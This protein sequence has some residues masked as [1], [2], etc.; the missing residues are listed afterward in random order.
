MCLLRG[1]AMFVQ[2][3]TLIITLNRRRLNGCKL[4]FLFFVSLLPFSTVRGYRLRWSPAAREIYLYDFFL[5]FFL[6]ILLLRGRRN[7]FVSRLSDL[8]VCIV[9]NITIA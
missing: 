2:I 4:Q 9:P 6:N 5:F 3:T 1:F 7:A 8:Y